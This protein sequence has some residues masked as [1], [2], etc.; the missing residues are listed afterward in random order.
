MSH[1]GYWPPKGRVYAPHPCESEDALIASRDR[2]ADHSPASVPP[3]I[4]VTPEDLERPRVFGL[5]ADLAAEVAWAVALDA[6]DA[7]TPELVSGLMEKCER[8][9]REALVGSPAR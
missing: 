9:I 1:D 7:P 2:M 4:G 5:I 8:A 3:S 6:D